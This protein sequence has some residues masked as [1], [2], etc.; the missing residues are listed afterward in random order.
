MKN[1][2]NWWLMILGLIGTIVVY[3]L[4]AIA[5]ISMIGWAFLQWASSDVHAEEPTASVI[6]VT[7]SAPE[8]EQTGLTF[9]LR[10]GYRERIYYDIAVTE[11]DTSNLMLRW[12]E[13]E[14]LEFTVQQYS[15]TSGVILARYNSSFNGW[16]VTAFWVD[17]GNGNGK[18]ILRF[19]SVPNQVTEPIQPEAPQTPQEAP[20]PTEPIKEDNNVQ[21]IQQ[22]TES[23]T[24]PLGTSEEVLTQTEQQNNGESEIHRVNEQTTPEP[25]EISERV[26]STTRSG[27]TETDKPSDNGNRKRETA[28][29]SKTPESE[30]SKTTPDNKTKKASKQATKLKKKNKSLIS[31]VKVLTMVFVGVTIGLSIQKVT[32][33][34]KREF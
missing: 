33:K 26:Q 15:K 12:N 22:P 31:T 5:F 3:I 7:Y 8:T 19:R 2:R 17:G 23:N 21:T 20:Q 10:E 28:T 24:E 29:S 16:G 14:G 1:N 30:S 11:G 4:G 9:A 32:Y 18:R 27:E 6:S 25:K 34:G 13:Y